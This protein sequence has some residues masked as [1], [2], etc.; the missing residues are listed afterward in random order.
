MFF[1]DEKIEK[2]KW[3]KNFE[4]YKLTNNGC[5]GCINESMAIGP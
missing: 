2:S 3:T 5:A 4:L 1:L